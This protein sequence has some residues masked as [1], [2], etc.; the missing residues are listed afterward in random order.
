MERTSTLKTS[1]DAYRR[2]LS[3][4]CSS[5][6]MR[7]ELSSVWSFP[8]DWPH[9]PWTHIC[10]RS[11]P[12]THSTQPRTVLWS[13]EEILFIQNRPR[14]EYEDCRRHTLP[15]FCI[16]AYYQKNYYTPPIT[17]SIPTRFWSS[18][19]LSIS[20]LIQ[21]MDR[22]KTRLRSAQTRKL[23]HVGVCL[24]LTGSTLNDI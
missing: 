20:F 10:P 22:S 4:A 3:N 19:L 24:S 8:V 5:A 11:I 2:E 9:D 7:K 16:H 12:V 1:P 17:Q 21:L 14:E 18:K 23:F 15:K 13:I 6:T